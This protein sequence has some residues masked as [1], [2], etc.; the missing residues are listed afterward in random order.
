MGAEVGDADVALDVGRH[1]LGGEALV[2][3]R[4]D[5]GAAAGAGPTLGHVEPAV[6]GEALEQHVGEAEH[7]RLAARRGVAHLPGRPS[8]RRR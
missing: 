8:V 3:W 2:A 1:D 4:G 6:A 5:A 7:R